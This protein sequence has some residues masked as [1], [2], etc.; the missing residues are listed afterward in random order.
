MLRR[1]FAHEHL[2]SPYCELTSFFHQS[3]KRTITVTF[4]FI[5]LIIGRS[6][7]WEAYIFNS[8]WYDDIAPNELHPMW[9]E[10]GYPF[11]K[12]CLTKHESNIT[13]SWLSQGYEIKSLN[14]ER[15][16][17]MFYRVEKNVSNIVLPK[18][19]TE[20]PLPREIAYKFDRL[21]EQFIKDNGL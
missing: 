7:P 11:H 15:G 6:L 21:V 4:R 9:Q 18:A 14:L 1:E 19:L 13:F 3:K 16:R 8:F 5:E 2:K 10:E 20:R 17:I 12:V